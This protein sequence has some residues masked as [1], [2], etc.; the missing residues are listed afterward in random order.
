MTDKKFNKLY[1]NLK[2]IDENEKLLTLHKD[3]PNCNICWKNVRD[4]MPEHDF[5]TIAK[6]WIGKHYK[7]TRLLVI[8]ENMNDYGGYDAAINLVNCSKEEIKKGHIKTLKKTDYSGTFLFHRLASYSTAILKKENAIDCKD[9]AIW[10]EAIDN[11][12]SFDYLSFTNQIK[13]SPFGQKSE[14]S[15]EMWQNCGNF[16]LKKEI[17]ILQPK[18]ILILGK[19]DNYNYFN[20]YIPD[21]KINLNWNGSIGIG[22][23]KINGRKT[24]LYVVPHP[25]SFGGNN[26]QIMI[27]LKYH[28]NAL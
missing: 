15:N 26:K 12:K 11:Y 20:S 10:P 25:A 22:L 14:Q 21:E 7:R 16:I 8:G 9:Y 18:N 17:E 28:I 4:R 27:D 24:K 13:C 6:P 19:S 3:C 5:W 23:V 2:L 1:K